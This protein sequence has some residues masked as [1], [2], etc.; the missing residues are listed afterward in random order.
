LK[1]SNHCFG[2]NSEQIILN[3][4]ETKTSLKKKYIFFEMIP[5]PGRD[6]RL[7]AR[8]APGINLGVVQGDS[9]YGENFVK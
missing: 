6:Q 3:Q 4:C 1:I 7:T 5:S 9:C 2:E 8:V